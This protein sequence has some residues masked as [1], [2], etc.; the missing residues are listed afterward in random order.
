[1]ELRRGRLGVAAGVALAAAATAIAGVVVE[2]KPVSLVT[3]NLVMHAGRPFVRLADLARALG[4]NGRW[5][6]ARLKYEIQP[7]PVGVLQFNPGALGP[8]AVRG[9]PRLAGQAAGR[10][11][12]ELGIG[13]QDVMI[14]DEEHVL[15]PPADPAV[16]LNFLARLLG[17]QARFDSGRGAWV[18]PPGGAGTPLRFR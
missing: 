1:M 17:G 12:F 9:T 13:G 5:D 2:E 8:L 3:N 4:G 10:N 15:L 6:P 7:G 11:S 18:L 14:G 16:A